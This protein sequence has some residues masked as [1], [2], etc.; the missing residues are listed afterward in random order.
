MT[1]LYRIAGLLVQS[2]VPLP[3]VA[4]VASSAQPPDAVIECAPVPSGLADPTHRTAAWDIGP[5]QFLLRLPDGSRLQASNGCRLLIQPVADEQLADILP[6]VLGTGIAALLYQ[7]GVVV[8]HASSVVA[9]GKAWLFCGHSGIGKS[10]LAAALCRAG[11]AFGGDD[12]AAIRLDA[13][14]VP[15]MASDG[16][17][18]KLLD[19]S[20]DTLDMG[21]LR[22]QE[23]RAGCGKHYVEP[24]TE[25]SAEP[26]PLGAIYFLEDG[27]PGAP[28]QLTPLGLI[29][30]AQSLLNDSYRP[31]MALLM[32]GGAERM[33][34]TTAILRHVPAFAL[35]RP[36][37]LQRLDATVGALQQHWLELDR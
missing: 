14:G 29:D 10:T 1:L 31:R 24:P 34:L 4:A 25:S 21:D 37:D 32:T 30:A 3:G 36:R 11:H 33:A 12:I 19:N 8:L 35:S 22:R 28:L 16:R 9:H 20:I 6:F 17:Q 2:S 7:R 27:L 15:C 26:L 13:Q 5:Q 18:L 23:V